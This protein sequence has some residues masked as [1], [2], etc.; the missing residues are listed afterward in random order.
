MPPPDPP[1]DD[2][3]AALDVDAMCRL[4]PV[5]LVATL[6]N[7]ALTLLVMYDGPLL[8]AMNAT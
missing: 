6:R 2:C 4:L 3:D 7:L 8:A 5:V 1:R